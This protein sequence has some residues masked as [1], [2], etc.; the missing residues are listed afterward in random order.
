MQV[1]H[2][3]IAPLYVSLG[4]LERHVIPRSTSPTMCHTSTKY[5]M[6]M[7]RSW[8]KLVAALRGTESDQ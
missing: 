6:M 2:Q 1:R 7:R 8:V 4:Q 5:Q 3:F